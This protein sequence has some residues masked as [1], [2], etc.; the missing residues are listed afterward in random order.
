[1][2]TRTL[3]LLALL[4]APS[5][6][7]AQT[8]KVGAKAP[9]PPAV[10]TPAPGGYLGGTDDCTTPM[11][12]AGQGQFPFDLSAATNGTQ[13]QSE[14]LCFA[15]G[16]SG[17]D[18]D[19]WFCWTA[20]A[21]GCAE[22][23]TCSLTGV[24]T[25]IAAYPGCGC[26]ANGSALACNDDTC[27]L[28]STISWPVT[29]G[30]TYTV[31]LGTFPGAGVG[32]GLFDISIP[33]CPVPNPLTLVAHYKL[34]EPA[35]WTTIDSSGNGFNGIYM[36]GFTLGLPGA[37]PGTNLSVELDDTQQGRSVIPNNPTFSQMRSDL[38]LAAWVNPQT[39][40]LNNGITRIFG[41]VLGSWQCGVRDVGLRFTTSGIQDYD[42]AGN[43]PLNTWTHV[44]F[45]F[46]LDFDVTFYVDGVNIGTIL[47]N[48][49]SG[50][51]SPEW[52]IGSFTNTLEYWD[53]QL[54]DI[55]VYSGAL[56][57]SEVAFLFANPGTTVGDS[58][59]TPY[60]FGDGSGTTCP[61][62]NTGG[63]GEGCAN[64]TGTGT[65]AFG[66]GSASAGADDLG[67]DGRNLLPA[68]PAL[69]FAGLNAVNNGNGIVFGDGLRCAGG[70]V[71]RLGVRVPD[72]NGDA[73]WG[74]GLGAIG[75]WVAGD[76]RRF[77]I[78]Y[79]DPLIGPCGTGFNLSNGVEVVFLP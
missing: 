14:P 77:Q 7:H 33:P 13:G 21:D 40:G 31:Q 53:G 48:A 71:V 12:I 60:C 18:S 20:D 73:S 72:G 65:L 30:T 45:V 41:N 37:H 55:Q 75:G 24:D 50:L 54:D 47:G 16:T 25:K 39:Y 38:S 78:W 28:Q 4:C 2:T 8:T 27:A 76:T 15:F 43:V 74:P 57:D 29:N 11:P 70:S 19:V 63:S 10:T 56:D 44:A 69:L 22:L 46:D 5:A 6:A 79:R 32:T 36:G 42:I 3:V 67:F 1:M 17:I 26:P 51:A 66:T 49:Q 9:T 64:S 59:G 23:S 52:R 68:Q 35:G 61:C 62:G 34:D 58:V